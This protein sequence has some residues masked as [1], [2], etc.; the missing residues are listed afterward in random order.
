MN[1][2]TP[3]FSIIIPLFNTEEYIG[4]CLDS[5]SNQNFDNYEVIVVDDGSTDDSVK[6]VSRYAKTNLNITLLQQNNSG[7]SAT[8]NLGL[9]NAIGEYIIFVDS[10]DFLMSGT[11]NY[12]Q[13]T[14]LMN[15][16]VDM[17]FFNYYEVAPNKV[18]E[19]DYRPQFLGNTISKNTAIEALL[20]DA[21]GFCWNKVYKRSL[22]KDKRFDQQITFLEDLL[23]NVSLV[24]QTKRIMSVE[25]HL[26]GYRWRENS[27][28]HTF[29]SKNMTFFD[30]LN[31]VGK[32]IPNEFH[33][34]LDV[35]R[36]MAC[37]EFASNFIFSNR[38]QYLYFK[39][40][41][42]NLKLFKR[43]E[44][45]HL[46]KTEKV[47]LKLANVNFDV[48]VVALKTKFKVDKHKIIK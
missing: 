21:G 9:D 47:S 6:I 13:N 18:E 39:K 44:D 30:A 11:L 41:Y 36:R 25:N 37:I 27:V 33:V 3:F 8:R 22:L 29:K 14:L 2:T 19:H 16:D 32:L 23:F 24:N 46:T 26:Y 1:S 10:D 28:I 20:T 40:M 43:F 15:N 34:F 45:T 35:K 17:L 5:I 42:K 7:V 4:E 48:A 38:D 12:L 31:K